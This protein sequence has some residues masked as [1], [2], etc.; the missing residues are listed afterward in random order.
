M[1]NFAVI[2]LKTIIKSIIKLIILILLIIGIMNIG[3]LFF[4]NPKLNYIDIV[5]DNLYF[6]TSK[7]EN[8]IFSQIITSEI[9]IL[10]SN[11]YILSEID[12]TELTNYKEDIV[13]NDNNI[14]INSENTNMN[15]TTENT[16]EQITETSI[17]DS[18][19]S[20]PE[21]VTT[22]IISE[23]NLSE[24][25][26]TTYNTVKIKNET[27]FNLTQDVLTPN[28]EYTNKNDII[29][30]HTHTC[31]SYTQTDANPYIASGNY[32]TT[33]LTHSVAEVGTI[34]TDALSSKGFNVNHS[35]TYHDYP[36]YNGSYNRSYT[37]V[38][39]LLNNSPNVQTVID[40]HRD[41]IGSMSNYAPCVQIGDEKV[42][43]LMFVIG[44]NGGG[45]S[46]NN[47]QNNLKFAIKIQE[48]ANEMYPGLF[49]PIIVRNSRYNQNLADSA[50][51]IEVGATGNTLEEA[52]GSMKYLAEVLNAVIKAD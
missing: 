29:I 37:T 26:N 25:Y 7:N 10:A 32:R 49:R 4:K 47:W 8:N 35:L 41:A 33:D 28:V 15:S 1:I 39:D 40:L 31:E 11:N 48:K 34:L 42:A 9:P 6:E 52:T 19:Y 16:I 2:N 50:F 45:L 44:T 12:D 17:N 5:K 38:S 27:N 24:S 51:I 30:F 20:I 13:D 36:A 43:Q 21:N 23:N 22:S 14:E 46:H 18:N 3:D